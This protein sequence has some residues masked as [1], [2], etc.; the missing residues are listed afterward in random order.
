MSTVHVV[1]VLF[2]LSAV[3][4]YIA[5]LNE[6]QSVQKI[7]FYK[8]YRVWVFLAASFVIKL[9]LAAAYKGF[10]A[11]MNCF[12]T[13]S[14][15]AFSG[16][17]RN[18]YTSGFCDYP[19]GYIYVLY[20]VGALR[21]I[22]H[23]TL[24]SGA[25]LIL[26]KLPAILCDMGTGV[27]IYHIAAKKFSRVSSLALSALYLLSP[28]VVLNSSTWGQVDGIL[29][30][31]LALSIFLATEHKLHLA[32]IV[33]VISALLKLQ[34]IMFTPVFIFATVAEIFLP[35]FDAKKLAK[36]A[37]WFLG[38]VALFLLLCVPFGVK[39]IIDQ[40][41][42]TLS[43][44]PFASVNAFN[45][46]TLFD[47]NWKNLESLPALRV[48]GKVAIV[49]LVL[50]AAFIFYRTDICRKKITSR[51]PSRYYFIGA[52]II[53]CMFVLSTKMHERYLFPGLILLLIAYVS[54][55]TCGH[56]FWLY[57][58]LTVAQTYN[59]AYVLFYYDGGTYYETI[60][61]FNAYAKPVALITLAAFLYFLYVAYKEY[62][63]APEVVHPKQ[64]KKR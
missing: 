12:S 45:T 17:L 40:L 46:Y 25:D 47:L 61:R 2:V 44:Y 36:L 62:I 50:F 38:S 4:L 33:F 42:N 39:T 13:W 26:L 60:D 48:W 35:K 59:T 55:P 27:L 53:F 10:D 64:K 5:V 14:S 41:I 52:A 18:F 21:H 24:Y 23:T 51:D 56:L 37:G 58:I 29:A 57:L 7:P 6:K 8:D 32:Y 28:A 11:D 31:G 15:R 54:R 43:S 49:L 34:A 19:P 9:C 30:F 3:F 1:S 16:G 20:A 22:F 63:K